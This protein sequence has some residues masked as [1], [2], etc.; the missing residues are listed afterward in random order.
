[1][2]QQQ[3]LMG[4][5][6][7]AIL[8]ITLGQELSSNV[9]KM[10]P[11][12]MI[13]KI[14]FEIANITQV[15]PLIKDEIL[16][17]FVETQRASQYIKEGGIDYAREILTKALGVK[18]AEE[19]LMNS[20]RLAQKRK[21]FL[22]AR[23]TEPLQLLKTIVNE[24]PQTIALILCF[25]QADR[26]AQVLSGLPEE[27]KADVAYRIATMN[28]TSPKVI[29]QVEQILDRKL[30]NVLEGNFESYGGIKTLV[31]ILNS[32]NRGTEKSILES[33]E[34]EDADLAEEIK[35]S[36]FVFEDI[37]NLEGVYVQRVLRD[38]DNG[39]L[40]LA[41]KGSSKEVADLIFSNISKRAA[42]TLRE[43]IEF[44]GPVKITAVEEAQHKIVGVIRRLDEAGEIII[45][46]GDQSAII[47]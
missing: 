32:S 19:I 14:T 39:E 38:V 10:L 7:A 1:M 44:M 20:E 33:L 35:D 15:E 4:V 3:E 23:K 2:A 11:E 31:E 16:T 37:V 36:M 18:K 13:E 45:S 41:L 6:K 42:E 12:S 21:P 17:E 46:R 30:S 25:L 8:F 26:A 27:M 5:E 47:V 28:K 24:H 29:K 34:Q 9:L 43:D 22:L 40:A